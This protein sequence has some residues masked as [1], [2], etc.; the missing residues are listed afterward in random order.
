VWKLENIPL[1]EVSVSRQRPRKEVH[2]FKWRLKVGL[3]SVLYVQK[4]CY[5]LQ[6]TTRLSFNGH[7]QKKKTGK[8]GT[9]K[10][11]FWILLQQRM[12]G[13]DLKP[14][15]IGLHS[16]LRRATDRPSMAT[17]RGNGCALRARHLM[18]KE[19]WKWCGDKWSSG[20]CK[21]PVKPS[22]CT[23]KP[24]P[25][26]LQPGCPSSRPNNG[27]EAPTGKDPVRYYTPKLSI[28]FFLNPLQPSYSPQAASYLIGTEPARM[29]NA[30]MQTRPSQQQRN[31]KQQFSRFNGHPPA[32]TWAITR[33]DRQYLRDCARVGLSLS[34]SPL[35]GALTYIEYQ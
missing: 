24:T 5:L 26:F 27:V 12:I 30:T 31:A 34:R 28:R 6:I 4:N 20:R 29:R 19:W 13:S 16:A 21:A 11:L 7:F 9:G 18:M 14:L 23:N 35:A 33:Q 10:F 22:P 8:A 32:R 1:C 25:S 3:A 2:V 17:H 15:N